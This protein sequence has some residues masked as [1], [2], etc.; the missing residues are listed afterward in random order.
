[1]RYLLWSEALYSENGIYPPTPSREKPKHQEDLEPRRSWLNPE[2]CGCAASYMSLSSAQ[3]SLAW[4]LNWIQQPYSRTNPLPDCLSV[5]LNIDMVI[6]FT[7][8]LHL[9]LCLLLATSGGL[10]RGTTS[11]WVVAAPTRLLVLLLCV[12]HSSLEARTPGMQNYGDML[13]H[14]VMV[15]VVLGGLPFVGRTNG[16]IRIFPTGFQHH[17]H[18]CYNKPNTHQIHT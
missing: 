5:F 7:F 12:W 11:S 9:C 13:L 18:T 15:L 8:R 17:L 6:L 1:M 2:P 3:D 4:A 14:N 10:P 16:P